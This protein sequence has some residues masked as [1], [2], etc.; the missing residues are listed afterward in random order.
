M[1]VCL[2]RI[3]HSQFVLNTAK[4]R[5]HVFT[6]YYHQPLSTIFGPSII[7]SHLI[8][9]GSNFDCSSETNQSKNSINLFQFWMILLVNWECISPMKSNYFIH[10]NHFLERRAIKSFQFMCRKEI[11]KENIQNNNNNE[12]TG[13]D[14]RRNNGF[15]Y[16]FNGY[17]MCEWRWRLNDT[18]A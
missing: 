14:T 15:I 12:Q 3:F 8:L 18:W 5:A 13:K 17:D 4:S 9:Y 10:L 2:S 16:W 1:L 11:E 6:G 7:V